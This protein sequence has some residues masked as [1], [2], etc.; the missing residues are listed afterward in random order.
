MKIWC[1]GVL[2][3]FERT[4]GAQIK[5]EYRSDYGIGPLEFAYQ[6]ASRRVGMPGALA[7]GYEHDHFHHLLSE[8]RSYNPWIEVWQRH[9]FPCDAF[10]RILPEQK[11]EYRSPTILRSIWLNSRT[12]IGWEG[13]AVLCVEHDESAECKN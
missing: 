7:I 5:F 1:E 8:V 6:A 10:V 4:Q 11:P 12:F 3:E 9:V 2:T 13:P